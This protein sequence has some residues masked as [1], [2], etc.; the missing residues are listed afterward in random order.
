MD[1]LRR[2]PHAIWF[3]VRGLAT[4][5]VG[6]LSLVVLSVALAL[7]LWL[8]VTNAENPTE[9]QTFNSAIEISFTNTPAG[10]A[11][12]NA[13]A[14]TVRIEIEAPE[15]DLADL[16]AADFTAD[17]NLGGLTEGKATVPVNVRSTNGNVRIVRTAPEQIEVTLESLR[18]KEVPVRVSPIG[19][20]VQ[21]FAAGES[22]VEPAS[23]TVSGP[24][25]L[26]D[27]VESAVAQPELTG[28][29]VDFT[30]DRIIL[31]PQ[32]ARGGEI[33][34]VTVNPETANV[35]VEIVQQEFSL[36][37][38]V[39]PQISGQPALGYNVTGV[40]VD[41]PVVTL[42][43]PLEELQSLDAIAGIS[44]TEV[45]IGDARA[46]V[47]RQ[48]ELTL[49]AGVGVIGSNQVLVTVS[50]AAARGEATFLVIPQIQNVGDGLAV[51]PSQSVSVTLSGDLPV[52]Q[53]L[54]PESIVVVADAEGLE[55]GF[56]LVVLQITAPSNTT[57][58]SYE[59]TELG[60]ALTP[61]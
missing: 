36:E 34:R 52:L 57:V 55:A 19:S 48:V 32:D 58:V 7:S 56:H 51:T 28:L 44:T 12:A 29:R 2:L 42:T 45:P 50:I 43:G 24:A 61:R 22:S 54:S 37:F 30:G 20:P 17:V 8:F 25:S 11:L 21:G 23:A 13:S 9:R 49:P 33:G 47:T 27:L 14:S 38:V 1:M 10:L 35:S 39:N 16:Q 18:T 15:R 31:R 40:S 59:P 3:F 53:A 46:S 4:S 60:I 26:V 41:P 5:I 6:N